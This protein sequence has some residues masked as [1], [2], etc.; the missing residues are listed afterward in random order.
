MTATKARIAAA[1]RGVRISHAI[2]RRGLLAG[3]IEAEECYGRTSSELLSFSLFGRSAYLALDPRDIG[4]VLHDTVSFQ[5]DELFLKAFRDLLGFNAVSVGSEEWQVVRQR[6]LRF[7][8]GKNLDGYSRI[9]TGVLEQRMIPEWRRKSRD[10]QPVDVFH[11]LLEYSSRVVFAAFLNVPPEDVPPHLHG[12]LNEMFDH[13]RRRVFSFVNLPIWIPTA[14]NRRFREL[15]TA[16]YEFIES[17]I[18]HSRGTGSMLETLVD[19]H[20][21]GGRVDRQRL[22]EEMLG[23]LIGGSETT[24]ILMLW[25]LYYLAAAPELQDRLYAEIAAGG[26]EPARNP[27]SLLYRCIIEALRVRS[28]SYVAVREA[29]R[30]V[31]VRGVKIIAGSHVFASQ[32]ITHNDVRVWSDPQRFDPDRFLRRLPRTASDYTDFFPFGAG[33]NICTGQA[34]AF[35]EAVTA[36]S[37]LIRRFRFA[38]AAAFDPAVRAELTLRPARQVVMRIEERP[39]S[40]TARLGPAMEVPPPVAVRR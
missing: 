22:L 18:A 5:R 30:P 35:Q 23:N 27:R 2:V 3:L 14:Q 7:L 29:V 13:V 28:P 12:M 38:P 6:T 15:R 10:G 1:V 24:I 34:Y 31:Q 21:T 4:L 11:D 36:V 19:V 20:S 32:F 39:A 8:T 16:V 9:M 25:T 40:D 37:T 33:R 26:P 17:R